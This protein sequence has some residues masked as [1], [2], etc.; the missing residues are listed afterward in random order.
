LNYL[1]ALLEREH[2]ALPTLLTERKR[3][4]GRSE[5]QGETNVKRP[6]A[7]YLPEVVNNVESLCIFANGGSVAMNAAL[8]IAV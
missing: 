3:S 5:N 2:A 6:K 1:Y 7:V 4:A 8:P